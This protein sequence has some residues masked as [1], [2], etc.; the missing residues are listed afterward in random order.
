MRKTREINRVL[1]RMCDLWKYFMETTETTWTQFGRMGCQLFAVIFHFTSLTLYYFHPFP[2]STESAQQL[3]WMDWHG[4][5]SCER[6][7]A[8]INDPRE[9]LLEIRTRPRSII[10]STNHDLNLER[11]DL[12]WQDPNT[13]PTT[14]HMR[15]SDKSLEKLPFL[16]IHFFLHGNPLESNA[17]LRSHQPAQ[18]SQSAKSNIAHAWWSFAKDWINVAMYRPIGQQLPSGWTRPSKV[19]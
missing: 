6:D 2:F 13:P 4:S 5:D 19:I 11:K 3:L 8:S 17:F 9:T 7:E 14:N 10:S 12:A 15:W 1:C 16:L 18:I